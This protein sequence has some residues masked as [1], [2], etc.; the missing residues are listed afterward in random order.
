L[1]EETTNAGTDTGGSPPTLQ[2]QAKQKPRI[3]IPPS[4]REEIEPILRHK[5]MG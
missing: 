5:K 2:P 1:E 4:L 3:P